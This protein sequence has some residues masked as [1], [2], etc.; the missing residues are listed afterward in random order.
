MVTEDLIIS[1]DD[2][3]YY[4]AISDSFDADFLAPFILQATDSIAERVLGTAL[5]RKLITDYNAGT[6]AG[7]YDTLYDSAEA[8]V[9]KMVCWETFVLSF[10]RM[11]VLIGNGGLT[12]LSG[13]NGESASRADISDIV[14]VSEATLLRYENQV[15]DYLA[16][17]SSSFIELQDNT[18]TYLKANMKSNNSSMNFSSTPNRVYNNF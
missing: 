13:A 16:Q 6:L 1:V 3:R 4:C 2:L 10:P 8:S 17:N 11:R 12:I 5:T 14:R 18:P 7:D 15:K 9:K